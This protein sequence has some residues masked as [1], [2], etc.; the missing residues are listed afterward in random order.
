LK[1][2]DVIEL[3]VTDLAYG[4]R[5]VARE[6]GKVIFV[7]KGLP[8]DILDVR[9]KKIKPDYCE[10]IAEK[11]IQ[12]SPYRCKPL[13]QH[14][15]ICGGC[16]WQNY[17]YNMQLRFKTEQL[18]QNLIH[19]GGI[20]DQPVEPIIGAKKIYFYR[21]KMEFSFHR[22]KD[23][24]NILGLHQA[25]FFD[26]VFDLSKCYLQSELSNEI[27]MFVKDECQRLHLPAYHIRKHDGLM[28]FL[29]IRES[30]FSDGILVNI[31]T[32]KDYHGYEDSIVELGKNLTDRFDMIKSLLW[33]INSKKANIAKWDMYPEK[34]KNGVLFG[35]EHIYEK[36]GRYSFRISADSFFQTNPYQAQILYDT[37]IDYGELS[38]FD[39]VCDLYCGTGAI[40][41][42]ISGLVKSV[43][44]VESVA[45]AVDDARINARENGLSN[46]D[47][48]VGNAEDIVREFKRFDKII[49][50]P[51]RAGL[52]P[53]VLEQIV[54][55]SPRIIIYVSCNPSTLARDVSG[56]VQNG[57]SLKRA[58]AVDM[59]PHTYHIESVV[60]LVR[61]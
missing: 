10:G 46:V 6:G 26:R 1:K 12:P 38:G 15:G 11:I 28:R 14:F 24:E 58:V 50:D 18:E 4:G 61:R 2:N 7:E 54:R 19:I 31:V 25:G 34:L 9:I 37:V 8:G 53:E 36:L 23:N 21:N 39:Y 41:I 45:Q 32:G 44:G 16:K 17:N 42:Y 40:S 48:I 49:L 29:V 3:Q 51:P 47:F 35:R 20:S 43:V 27:V 52:H 56:F 30:K 33:T 57:Y 59:F 13:C 22:N 55:I 60:K 5:G